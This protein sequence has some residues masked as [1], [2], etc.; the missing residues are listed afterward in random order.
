MP[1]SNVPKPPAVDAWVISQPKSAFTETINRVCVAALMENRRIRTLGITSFTPGEGKSSV[2][3]NIGHAAAMSG[4]S[5]LLVD[6]VSDERNLSRRLMPKT[7]REGGNGLGSRIERDGVIWQDSVSG[8]QFLPIRDA[9]EPRENSMW[10][11]VRQQPRLAELSSN[12][13]LVIFDLPSINKGFMVR[14]A[15]Q[16]L[17]ALLLVIEYG[18]LRSDDA[19]KIFARS[20]AGRGNVLGVV[21]NKVDE[22]SFATYA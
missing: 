5:V 14:A 11:W 4:Q 16:S 19:I 15:A 6:T 20:G 13:E 17:D 2:A 8:L 3:L 22:K 9:G 10:F 7:D 1:S 12:Y 21:L 18:K